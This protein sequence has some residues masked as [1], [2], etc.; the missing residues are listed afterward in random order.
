MFYQ[1]A[2]W[3]FCSHEEDWGPGAQSPMSRSTGLNLSRSQTLQ[4]STQA[5]VLCPWKMWLGTALGNAGP[6]AENMAL[7][8]K[9]L[10]TWEPISKMLHL[11]TLLRLLVQLVVAASQQLLAEA[12]PV[13]KLSQQH[14]AVAWDARILHVS[15]VYAICVTCSHSSFWRDPR[16]LSEIM[17]KAQ[18]FSTVWW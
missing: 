7:Q 5:T 9:H 15:P 13:L 6:A 14:R 3:E 8:R 10:W 11:S 12:V 4:L 1:L 18:L 16:S 17:M 2:D